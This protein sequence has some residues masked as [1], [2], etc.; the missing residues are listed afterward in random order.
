[1]AYPE[2]TIQEDYFGGDFV[3]IGFS[4]PINFDA[5]SN[6]YFPFDFNNIEDLGNNVYRFYL[7]SGFE[8]WSGTIPADELAQIQFTGSAAHA[9]EVHWS[10]IC[11]KVQYFIY[12]QW[13]V[14][15]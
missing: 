2:L 8:G 6:V 13:R 15:L 12:S 10:Q 9:P 11:V 1:M 5:A 14:T 4:H 7:Q 3:E